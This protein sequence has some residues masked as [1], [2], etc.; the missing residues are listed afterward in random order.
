MRYSM[1]SIALQKYGSFANFQLT[2]IPD[3]VAGRGEV[4]IRVQASALNPADYKV[5]LGNFKFLHARNFP[6]ILGYDFSGIVESVGP[7]SGTFKVGD[8]VFG[9]L[10]YSF[11][12]RRGTFAELV[13]AR[14]NEIAIKPEKISHIDAAAAATSGVTAL[15]SLRDLG[16]VAKGNRVLIT[17]VSG[18]VGSIAVCVAHKLGAEVVAIGSGAGLELAKKL[19]AVQ[20][21]DRSSADLLTNDTG[22]FDVVF[23]CASAYSW[24]MFKT[25]LKPG[26]TYVTL[27]PSLSF[28][29]DKILTLFAKSGARF[30]TGCRSRAPDLKLLAEML[31]SGMPVALDSTIPIR[32]IAKGLE[33]LQT[34]KALGKIAVDVKNGF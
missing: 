15:Q 2:D 8:A 11:S 14:A 25:K 6:M 3:P 1:R 18:G 13:V 21:I 22:K 23:D 30:L 7:E 29:K 26:G 33:R 24:S 5:A 10:P 27:L 9:F 16:R 17:G 31:E 4:L 28:L 20:T 19:G 34:G 32:D 12:N